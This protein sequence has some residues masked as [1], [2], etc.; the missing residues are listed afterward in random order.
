MRGILRNKLYWYK[1]NLRIWRNNKFMVCL[2]SLLLYK[3][4]R[5]KKHCWRSSLQKLLM[6]NYCT[7]GRKITFAKE[8][9]IKFILI[10]KICWFLSKQ[11][12][13]NWLEGSHH[14]PFH[15]LS[16]HKNA[17]INKTNSFCF[18][19]LR[20]KNYPINKRDNLWT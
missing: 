5:M 16:Y 19:S 9:L 15:Q 20:A 8:S 7:K 11:K 6:L 3:R 2:K 14:C 1:N 13:T 17:N 12:E 18:Q 4:G 10:M